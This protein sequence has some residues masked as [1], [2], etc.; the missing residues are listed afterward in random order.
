MQPSPPS[1]DSLSDSLREI[2]QS[3]Y[4]SEENFLV[5]GEDESVTLQYLEALTKLEPSYSRIIKLGHLFRP[6]DNS[7]V[8]HLH[9]DPTTSEAH[10]FIRLQETAAMRPDLIIVQ[11]LEGEEAWEA[12]LLGSMG[13]R[14]HSTVRGRSLEEGIHQVVNMALRA[15]EDLTFDSVL[16]ILGA[17]FPYYLFIGQDAEGIQ[18]LMS[19]TEVVDG[20][21]QTLFERSQDME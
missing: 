18:Q 20:K 3:I 4:Q 19:I 13:I 5:I 17:A 2:T 14:V 16:K 15:S 9:L 7:Q 8:L 10:R 12:I 6:E 21:L 1:L 11:S